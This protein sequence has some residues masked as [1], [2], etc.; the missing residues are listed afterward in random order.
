LKEKYNTDIKQADYY[1]E[2]RDQHRGWFQTSAIIYYLIHGIL[3]YKNVLVHGFV[4]ASEN[5]KIS[6][7]NLATKKISDKIIATPIEVIR[8]LIFASN[9]GKDIIIDESVIEIFQSLYIKIYNSLRFYVNL[10]YLFSGYQDDLD[11]IAGYFISKINEY[12]KKY[13]EAINNKQFSLSVHD[14]QNML[15]LKSEFIDIY[16]C[17]LYCKDKD[18][19]ELKKAI[20]VLNYLHRKVL[21][22]IYPI[23]PALAMYL[24]DKYCLDHV[25]DNENNKKSELV[26]KYLQDSYE[27]KIDANYNVKL[28]EIV[29]SIIEHINQIGP[30]KDY[31]LYVD[32]WLVNYIKEVMLYTR[33]SF[34]T[35]EEKFDFINQ[36]KFIIDNNDEQCYSIVKIGK[37][38]DYFAL[39]SFCRKY[40]VIENQCQYCNNLI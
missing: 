34:I 27:L 8:L 16:R 3:P 36:F 22:A 1:L 10:N 28:L 20:F 15:A 7:S 24:A 38:K 21:A 37:A 33:V 9:Y 6:K 31:F 25:A 40:C 35:R 13:A 23:L 39:C 29:Q 32:G 26:I 12:Y 2:G 18:D 5:V 30:S 11:S 4:Q 14:L 19:V 17:T